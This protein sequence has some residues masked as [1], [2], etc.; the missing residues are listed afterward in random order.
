MM[1]SII[2]PIYNVEKY[3]SECLDSVL[4]QTCCDWEAICVND[5]STD[6]SSDILERYAARDPRFKVVTQ[7]NGGL[8]SARN[9][10]LKAA[11]GEYVIFLDSDDWLELNALEVLASRISSEDMLCFSG[12]RF[13]ESEGSYHP[14]DELPERH[15]QS[16]MDYYNDNAL[17]SR[18]FAFV[19][20]VLRAYRRAYLE[21][22]GLHFKEGIFHEDNLFTPL[23]C[24][25]A[26]KV[27]TINECLYNYRVRNESITTTINPQ[28]LMDLM[29]TANELAAFFVPKKGFDKTVVFR[30]ITHH[31]QV[32]FSEMMDK[33]VAGKL[34]HWKL[35]RTVSRTKLRHRFNYVLNRIRSRF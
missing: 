16:G 19:C 21:E 28:R 34:C 5:G 14:A 12:R 3:L 2:I 31:Y 27:T 29:G 24:Y 8:S 17:M 18:D 10:G 33:E 11:K 23:A 15:Y 6:K 4:N 35:Y 13:F 32:V 7:P 9:A 22:N 1:F 30:A 25:H 20:V 26:H